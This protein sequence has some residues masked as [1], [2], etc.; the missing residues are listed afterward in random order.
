MWAKATGAFEAHPSK[1]SAT[2]L[3]KRLS[4][5]SSLP[6]SMLNPAADGRKSSASDDWETLTDYCTNHVLQL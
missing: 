4:T 1:A 2:P 3:E 5:G 6:D